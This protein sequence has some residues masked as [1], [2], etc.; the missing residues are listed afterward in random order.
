[1]KSKTNRFFHGPKTTLGMWSIGLMVIMPLLFFIGASFTN[2]L[3]LSVPSGD[4]ILQD[5]A[6][7]PALALTMLAGMASGILAFF[8]GFIAIVAKKERSIFVY[9]ST[10]IGMLLIV[11]LTGEIVSPH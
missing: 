11:I 8:T 4:S 5:V 10:L 3:Y 2:S 7:R 9:F 1:M 6:L